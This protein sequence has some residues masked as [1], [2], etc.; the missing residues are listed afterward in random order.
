MDQRS[1]AISELMG[2][3]N[4]GGWLVTY[5]DL[6]TLLLTFFI[7]LFSISSMN[8]QKFKQAIAAIQVSLGEK[9]APVA[10]LEAASG[11]RAARSRGRV[12]HR[13]DWRSGMGDTS[14]AALA[15]WRAAR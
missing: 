10:L 12:P 6:M 5:A 11:S 8:L 7:L 2:E 1:Q 3:G 13:P 14:R 4:P 9:T 15:I